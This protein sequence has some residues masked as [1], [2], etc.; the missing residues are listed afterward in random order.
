M[1]KL[2]ILA[3]LC[4]AV[5]VTAQQ[6]VKLD[7]ERT[8]QLA[9]D[10]SLTAD[11]YRSVFQEAHYAWL[12]WMAGRK[13][14]IGLS[15]TPLQYEQF[16][17]QRYISNTDN[18]EYR[19]QKRLLSSV[20]LQA[21]Q[22]MERWG[23][24]FYASTGLSYL[25]NYGD[26]D[27]H[28]FAAVPVRVGYKQELLGY[29]PYRWSRQ[30]EPMRLTV[31]QQQMNYSVEQTG[32]EAVKRF[33]TLAVAQEQ[34]R[35]A[36]EQ[37]Q[38]SDTIL[39]IGERRFRIASI[40]K[41]ELEILTLQRSLATTSL[42]SAQLSHQ[43]AV[44]SLAVW[45]GMD[46]LTQLELIVPSILPRLNVT[47]GDAI[48][49]ATQHNPNYLSM[50]LKELEARRDA[51]QLKRKKGLNASI[52]ASVGLNQVADRFEYAYRRPLVQNQVTVNLTV[53]IS[54][55]GKSRNAWLAA[56]S[57]VE[58]TVRQRQEQRRDTELDV[59]QTVAEVNQRQSMVDDSR[60]S[61]QIAEDAYT[62]MLQRFVRGQATVNDLSL[63]QQYWLD[64][65]RSQIAALQD[66]WNS[67][68]H[69]RQLTLYDFLKHQP[70]RH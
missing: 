19:E 44:K 41:A 51:D 53:P 1:R 30:T 64:A 66:F 52:D 38:T 60:H 55:H 15:T 56:Q 2:A 63:A 27:Q 67:Y 70:I 7:L 61:L 26:Y 59:A 23:G 5:S 6:S 10:S 68:Y 4:T 42:K 16:M 54:D 8:F 37:L 39:A 45:L 47:V 46:E 34:L 24:S 65:R 22:V 57:K 32:V 35:M 11:R 20:N 9:T 21:Q 40:S 12:S 50:E 28:Q 48:D 25:G 29:N 62:A 43:K 33:F 31:A 18:D 14:Q 49:Q 13:P 36:Q 69:L 17:V 58:T 3:L